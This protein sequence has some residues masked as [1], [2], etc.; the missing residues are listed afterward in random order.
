[1]KKRIHSI[2]YDEDLKQELKN[3]AFRAAFEAGQKRL[4]IA[5]QIALARQKA[6]MTQKEMAKKLKISQSTIA[7]IESGGQNLT[8]S[9][10]EKL[11]KVCGKNLR[12]DFI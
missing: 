5:Y 6:K 2:S 11:A 10:L 7:R 9:T 3:P 4:K 12:I 8:M 1:M